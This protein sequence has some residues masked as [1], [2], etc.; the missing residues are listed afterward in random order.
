MPSAVEAPLNRSDPLRKLWTRAECEKLAESGGLD[1]HHLELIEG[2]LINKTGKNQPHI[3]SLVILMAW[4]QGVFGSRRVRPEAPIDVAPEDN[5][6]NEPEP[7]ISV[8]TRDLSHFP[9]ERPRPEHLQLVVEVSDTTLAFD[10]GTKAAPYAR[11]GIVEYWV[12]DILLGH[13][14]TVHRDPR[15]GRY[16]SVEAYKSAECVAPL[17]APEAELR[18]GDVFADAG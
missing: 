7:D 16:K 8:L 4:L 12:L 18:V 11:A 5:P 3:N 15:G 9:K 13:Q 14:M 6:T 2:A 17:A 1:Y 10:L